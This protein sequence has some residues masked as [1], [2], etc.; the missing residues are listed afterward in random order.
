MS[1]PPNTM[2][3]RLARS[4]K[5]LI[6][7]ER[8]SVRFPSRMVPICVSEPMGC[9]RPR[10]MAATPAMVVV[11]TAPN[12]TSST[13]SFPC[14]GAMFTGVFTIGRSYHGGMFLQFFRTLRQQRRIDPLHVTMTGVR[15]GERFVQIGCD[16][17]ALL[18][19]LAGKV[20]LSGNCAVATF[21]EA[22]A[23]RARQVAVEV[24]A[25]MD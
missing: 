23:A 2:S 4:T 24:G 5:S 6:R 15:M 7:G 12:P 3:S 10:R 14:A 22:T 18:G 16:D 9:A 19:G 11:L 1:Q 20:G 8:P 17:T 25:L 13:P 21:D